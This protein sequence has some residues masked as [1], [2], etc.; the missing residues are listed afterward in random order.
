M[1]KWFTKFLLDLNLNIG[2]L[3]NIHKFIDC[4]LFLWAGLLLSLI[5]NSIANI[6]QSFVKLVKYELSSCFLSTYYIL[7][8]FKLH[9]QTS[10]ITIAFTLLWC[11]RTRM[12]ETWYIC[13]GMSDHTTLSL[14]SKITTKFTL[15]FLMVLRF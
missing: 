15:V 3:Y 9:F 11:K 4:V 1:L 8:S 6:R 13:V 2:H 7:K 10:T 14:F 12:L 5:F